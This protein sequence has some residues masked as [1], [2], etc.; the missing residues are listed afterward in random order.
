MAEAGLKFVHDNFL[1]VRGEKTV[2]MSA[3]IST[4]NSNL[5]VTGE[6]KGTK[7]RPKSFPIGV[8][9]KGKVLTGDELEIQIEKWVRYGTIELSCGQALKQVAS[10]PKWLDLS[11]KYFVLLGA[12]SAMGPIKFLLEHGANI[13][14]IDINIPRIWEMLFDYVKN[15]CGTMYFPLAKSCSPQEYA[16]NAGCNLLTQVP[17]VYAWLSQVCPGKSLVVGGYA[18]L[19]ADRFVRL[20]VAMDAIV[21]ELISKRKNIA[22]AYLC[23]PTDCH[24]IPAPAHAAEKAAFRAEAP[25]MKALRILSFG[26]LLR[27]N[28]MK[29][30]PTADGEPLYAVNAIVI[31]QG[32]NY[33]L[34]KRIQHWRCIVA[35]ERDHCRVST[36]IAP[37]T[38]TASVTK[39]RS[40][41]WAYNGMHNFKP[42]EVFQQDTSNAVMGTLLLNDVFNPLSVA[43]PDVSLRNP[44]QLFS[45]T[46]FH[47]GPWRTAHLFTTIG[48][49]SALLYFWS[50]FLNYYLLAYNLFQAGGWAASLA[51]VIKALVSGAPVW[52][53]AGCLVMFFQF[54]AVLEIAHS[55]LGITSSPVVQTSIQIYSRLMIAGVVD[56]NPSVHGLNYVET[57]LVA[58]AITEVVRYLYYATKL[59]GIEIKVLTWLRYHLFFVLYPTGVAGELLSTYS[60]LPTMHANLTATAAT[61]AISVL[62][63]NIHLAVERYLH[64]EVSN[65]FKFVVFPAYVF[66]LPF[67]YLY[68]VSQRNKLFGGARPSRSAGKVKAA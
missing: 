65:Y 14:A 10:T 22:L 27:P 15:S 1:F 20:S 59:A 51:Y 5:F 45:D 29:P 33:I 32:P 8:P 50:L 4:F 41:A 39:N 49:P 19:D 66:G 12:S 18:Y 53:E 67:L 3:A 23:T 17:E 16:A 48:V 30:L 47:G 57:M 36:N 58:W 44:L 60:A 25:W 24:L 26:K 46:A 2:P 62:Y 31:D 40:F 21:A 9:Y 54:L 6:V 13:I 35:R 38:A 42:M 43:N 61:S 56:N 63:V 52:A 7:P 37:S 34:A 64:I 55:V 28:A 68:M 11:D